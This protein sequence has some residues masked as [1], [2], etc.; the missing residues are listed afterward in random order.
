[1]TNQPRFL[2]DP[3]TYRTGILRA[4]DQQR[5][6][7][8]VF[9]F[10]SQKMI[11][12]ELEIYEK[13]GK[14]QCI[15]QIFGRCN[16]VTSDLGYFV[17]EE[18][19]TDLAEF[20]KTHGVLSLD[21]AC[22]VAVSI[23]EVL[24][25]AHSRNI[26]H[27]DIKPHNVLCS[28][29]RNFELKRIAVTDWGLATDVSRG[30]DSASKFV[31]TPAYMSVSCTLGDAPHVLDDVE[32]LLYL[33]QFLVAGRLPW[34]SSENY[35]D[36]AALKKSWTPENRS[37]QEFLAYARDRSSKLPPHCDILL[38]LLINAPQGE[39]QEVLDRL[40]CLYPMG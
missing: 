24:F 19:D 10:A 1:M 35:G 22:N 23:L 32:S 36:L 33:I 17:M 26:I 9:K 18:Y 16:P 5:G 37:L 30:A 11:R 12:R 3:H 8:V 6:R 2:P 27:R 15:P 38:L 40:K 34:L 28:I 20:V 4:I 25:R 21:T 7:R 13:L 14:G 31:G 39:C 29:T